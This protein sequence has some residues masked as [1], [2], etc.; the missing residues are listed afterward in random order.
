M[1]G[2][3][4]MDQ[5]QRIMDDFR[6]GKFDVLLLSQVGAEGLD[7]EFCNALVNY[8]LPWNPMQVE[9]RIGRLDRFGQTSEKIFIFNMHVPGTIESDI[10]ERLY[11]RIGL[12]EQSIGE[13]E[14][15]LRD[16]LKSMT[17]A[18]LDPRLSESER[19]AEAE[20][21]AVALAERAQ[22]VKQLEEARGALSTVDQLAGRRH[23][24]AGSVRRALHRALR[25]P[26]ARRA[27]ARPLRRQA[28]GAQPH[29]GSAG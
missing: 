1:T 14:P 29:A 15:I 10:F 2:G 4:P 3:T 19:S 18:L 5:R 28:D 12:F 13:L 23:D 27:P 11:T 24:R 21:M 17:R 26:A 6:A 8:D 9:Q 7:F 16:E 25:G 22:Q 20:R